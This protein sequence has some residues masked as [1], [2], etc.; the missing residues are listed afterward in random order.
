MNCTDACLNTL[1]CME[2]YLTF[3]AYNNSLD[4]VSI[5]R[6]QVFALPQLSFLQEIEI[7]IQDEVCFTVDFQ[8]LA[9]SGKHYAC[10]KEIYF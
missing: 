2:H 10:T 4:S 3:N 8:D 7:S 6:S 9:T 5:A 1:P